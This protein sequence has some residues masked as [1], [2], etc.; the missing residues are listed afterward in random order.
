MKKSHKLK[1]TLFALI[2]VF[3]SG[4]VKANPYI[5]V[6]VSATDTRE[7]TTRC[8][9]PL[10]LIESNVSSQTCGKVK[11]EWKVNANTQIDLYRST[12]PDATSTGAVIA[13]NVTRYAEN[14]YGDGYHCY[15]HFDWA[16][17][18]VTWYYKAK[19][20]VN[21]DVSIYLSP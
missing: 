2:I 19:N 12:Q 16:P 10:G 8:F 17:V 21:G 1:I 11:I 9:S 18:G 5:V 20:S 13:E 6:M 14:C 15:R 7:R 3:I 4:I